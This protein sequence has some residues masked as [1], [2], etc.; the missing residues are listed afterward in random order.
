MSI[1]TETASCCIALKEWAATC[2][3]LGE[4]RQIVLLRKGGI[5]DEDGVFRLE[6]AT[7][8]LQPTYLHQDEK[9]VKPEHRALFERVE[10]ERAAGENKKFIALRWFAKVADVFALT[11]DDEDRL[12]VAPHI[13]SDAY[14]DL[15]FGYKPQH[16]LLCVALRVYEAP[17]S[18]QL[19]MR[20]EWMGCRSWI[21]TE[22]LSLQ[23]ARP[24]LED[25]AFAQR[26]QELS[27]VLRRSSEAHAAE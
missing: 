7:F 3:A 17:A 4:G 19:P 2:R 16:P 8:W 1:Q 21:E 25:T 24:A 15:R 10:T 18:V 14:L 26:L 27:D 6:H 5:L 12:R 22:A 13:W 11:P 9:L 23:G 20:P